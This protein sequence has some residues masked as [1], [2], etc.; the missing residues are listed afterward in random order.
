MEARMNE[1]LDLNFEDFERVSLHRSQ[2]GAYLD[3]SYSQRKMI[4]PYTK[5]V[6]KSGCLICSQ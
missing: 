2:S 4:D 6:T 1:T 5:G 3:Y